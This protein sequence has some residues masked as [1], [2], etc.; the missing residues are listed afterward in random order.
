[1][2]NFKNIHVDYVRKTLSVYVRHM[3][4]RGYFLKVIKI[5][6]K[7]SNCKDKFAKAITKFSF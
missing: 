1:M 2:L 6:A 5:L 3:F 4:K 7:K